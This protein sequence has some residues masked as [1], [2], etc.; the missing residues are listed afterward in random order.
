MPETTDILVVNDYFSKWVK[1]IQ[2]CDF[3]TLTVSDFIWTHIIYRFG[4]PKTITSNN[5]QPFKNAWLPKLY[6][7]YHIKRNHCSWHAIANGLAEAFNKTLCILEKWL[8]RIKILGR[9]KF[10]RLSGLKEHGEPQLSPLQI[11]WSSRW[12]SSCHWNT[13]PTLRVVVLRRNDKWGKMQPALTEL[14]ALEG[15]THSVTEFGTELTTN[16]QQTHQ[17]LAIPEGRFSP[18]NSSP[19]GYRQK[20]RRDWIN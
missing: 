11:P 8:T 13:T 3:M 10:Q 9:I 14:E 18:S 12:K 15:K 7:K 5:G 2:V 4:I 19:H 17:T 16:V 20:E 6:V 1:A